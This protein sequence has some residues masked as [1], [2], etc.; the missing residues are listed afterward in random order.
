MVKFG[1]AVAVGA[2]VAGGGG[3]SSAASSSSS[4]P[5]SGTASSSSAS[6]SGT[7]GTSESSS[8][9]TSASSSPNAVTGWSA[10]ADACATR[11][12][13]ATLANTQGAAG[14]T[15]MNIDFT[16]TGSVACTL[17]GY[18]GVSIGSGTPFSQVGAS[19]T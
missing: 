11:N 3:G 4:V 1:G 12:L 10:T 2:V 15:Y 14:S 5:P 8:S 7:S 13:K 16:N 6:S 17:F 9:G 18:P 19:A